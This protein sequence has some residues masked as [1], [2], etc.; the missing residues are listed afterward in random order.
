LLLALSFNVSVFI[1]WGIVTAGGGGGGVC[2][3]ALKMMGL[4][5]M[6]LP[7]ALKATL[8]GSILD[9]ALASAEDHGFI[10]GE[11]FEA[12]PQTHA[13]YIGLRLTRK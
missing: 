6:H 10:V 4:E 8:V 7:G 1:T 12:F 2:G 11:I 3:A 9:Y 5:R 13:R